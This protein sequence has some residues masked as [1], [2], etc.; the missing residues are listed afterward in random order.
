MEQTPAQ[1]C[2]CVL[3]VDINDVLHFKTTV[4]TDH[5]QIILGVNK[6]YGQFGYE[7]ILRVVE[8]VGRFVASGPQTW[9][10]I[11]LSLLLK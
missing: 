11:F 10:L 4:E 1:R 5:L 7:C 3:N 8:K 6:E 9:A 2:S